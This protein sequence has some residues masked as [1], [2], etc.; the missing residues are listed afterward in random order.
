MY[1]HVRLIY[2]RHSG[3]ISLSHQPTP[4][5]LMLKPHPLETPEIL[6]EVSKHVSWRTLFACARV[7]KAWYQT[8]LPQIWKDIELTKNKPHPPGAI[9]GYMCDRLVKTL[10]ICCAL[11]SEHSSLI[12]PNLASLTVEN[13]NWNENLFK[14]VGNHPTLTHLDL[15]GDIGTHTTRFLGI[16]AGLHR[17][18]DLKIKG[19]EVNE[20]NVDTFWQLC[21]QLERLDISFQQIP[22]QDHHPSME[23]PRMRELRVR[24]TVDNIPWILDFMQR[25][26]G[27]QSFGSL[28]LMSNRLFLP[29]IAPL[30]SA[31]TWPHLQSI[32]LR[33][34]S[35]DGEDIANV[36]AGMQRIIAFEVL[37][38]Y[39]TPR[40][41]DLLRPHFIHLHTLSIVAIQGFASAM[42]QEIMS[43]CPSLTTF[44]GCKIRAVDIVGGQPW[45]CL[46]LK[47]LK[48]G[49]YADDSTISQIQPLVFDQ[50]SRLTQ[51][52][53]LH[54]FWWE[55]EG[56]LLDL[57]LE[58]G[59]GR[60][61]K[62]RS[63]RIL[64]LSVS[65]QMIQQ[66][67]VDWMLKHWTN[68]ERIH[69]RLNALNPALDKALKMKLRH[70]GIAVS[71]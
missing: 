26:P 31:G 2:L 12:L 43:S 23:L 38:L 41:M 24:V 36:V 51:L 57:R 5:E 4:I 6:W 20:N 42:A 52:Q 39:F 21:A 63:L 48:L 53:E 14:L 65:Q 66:P 56:I 33:A 71:L 17:L 32:A 10:R 58:N 9:H 45:V 55:T 8:F 64:V 18:K 60:L 62:L 61:S 30:V 19:L 28:A 29:R 49:I 37:L 3:S 25:C 15:G 67:E 34:S 1:F 50:L 54:V 11:K 44:K 22:T 13:A 59:L 7:S 68:L 16:L 40:V 69:G 35:K 70:H 46:K 47:V 27:L